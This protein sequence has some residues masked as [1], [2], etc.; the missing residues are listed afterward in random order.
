MAGE[1]YALVLLS[2][3][4]WLTDLGIIWLVGVSCLRLLARSGGPGFSRDVVDLEGRL[5]RHAG[6][7]LSLLVAATVARLYAQTYASFG[8]DEPVTGELL[9]LVSTQTRWGD[10][11][12]MQG[13]AV[14]L[15]ALAG[16]LVTL[17]VGRSWLLLGAAT[18]VVVGTTPM[19]GHAMG[20]SGGVLLPMVLQIAHLL[21]A[22]AWIGTLFVLLSTGFRSMASYGPKHGLVVAP[23][24]DRFSPVALTA[25]G[26]LAGTGAVT[27]FLY[28]D[29]VQQLWQTVYG[30][31]LMAKIVLFG[32]AVLLG[33]YNW[34]RVRPVI[35]SPGG[36]DRLRWSGAA[37]LLVVVVLLAVTAWLVHLPMPHE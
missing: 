21:A 31:A 30:R 22:G 20:Y 17:R 1:T 16:V 7:A 33:A 15:S 2:A 12:M 32:V 29:E 14:V 9:R 13:A 28:I 8:L 3:A 34:K 11:W 18:L 26:T 5:V 19:T 36:V 4:K 6:L 35:S 37:E 24:V 25:A 10:R 27:A 23:L